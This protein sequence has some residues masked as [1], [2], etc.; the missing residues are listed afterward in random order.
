M[1]K[2]IINDNRKVLCQFYQDVK[3]LIETKNKL[4]HS[5]KAEKLRSNWNKTCQKYF[6]T[7]LYKDLRNNLSNIKNPKNQTSANAIQF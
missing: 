1:K 4:V 3:D 2:T 7:F 5:D 6:K